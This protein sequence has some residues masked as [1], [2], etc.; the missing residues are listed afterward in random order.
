MGER[1][2]G[3]MGRPCGLVRAEEL[4]GRGGILR[5]WASW[6][7]RE[8]GLRVRGTVAEVTHWRKPRQAEEG[9][10]MGG[11]PHRVCPVALHGHHFLALVPGGPFFLWHGSEEED[12]KVVVPNRTWHG[13][14][15][16]AQDASLA[17]RH[18]VKI[19]GWTA[20]VACSDP[21]GE[22]SAWALLA[23]WSVWLA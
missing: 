7:G 11:G 17:W 10:F 3:G 20:T 14:R 9:E 4:G 23:G 16:C 6:R 2:V 21:P 12:D 18:G 22:A 1:H 19:L 8:A 5:G 13:Q 15:S